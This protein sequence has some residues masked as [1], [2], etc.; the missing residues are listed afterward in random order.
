[1]H[2]TSSQA[3]DAVEAT[4]E[5]GIKKT[6]NQPNRDARKYQAWVDWQYLNPR[7]EIDP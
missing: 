1:L 4:G 3:W 2:Y 6:A 5:W 7:S